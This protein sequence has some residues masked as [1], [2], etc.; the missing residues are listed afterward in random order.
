MNTL[1]SQYGTLLAYAGKS[2]ASQ[3]IAQA[4]RLL[5]RERL[6]VVSSFG[7]ESAVLLDVV[8]QVDP[9]I[10]VLFLETGRHFPETLTYK[11]QLTKRLGL[12]DVRDL[13]P[14]P[15]ALAAFDPAGELWRSNS[16]KCCS[17][18]KVIPLRQ[19]LKPFSC[20]INGRKRYQAD[21]RYEIPKIELVDGR[22]KLNPLSEFTPQDVADWFVRRDLPRHP[23]QSDGYASISCQ[24][25]T[26]PVIPGEPHRAGRWRGSGKLECG[27]HVPTRPQS[28]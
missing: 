23:L 9:A 24:P 12:T 4:V 3:L 14:Q 18:R 6:C 15:D 26:A 11:A 25:C 7:T 22:I 1:P 10:P 28:K 21:T 5:G 20:W 19:A 16:D 27:I 13:V 2:S 8:A 17:I